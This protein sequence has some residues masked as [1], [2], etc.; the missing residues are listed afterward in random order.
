MIY[1]CPKGGKRFR[2]EVKRKGGKML[3]P[4]LVDTNT[5]HHSYE[6]MDIIDYLFETYAE[7]EAPLS[8]KLDMLNKARAMVTSISRGFMGIKVR[9]SKAPAIIATKT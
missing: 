2:P 9:A 6:S 7:K 8:W 5:G 3:F 1:P 4:Y